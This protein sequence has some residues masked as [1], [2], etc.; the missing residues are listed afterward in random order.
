MK[1]EIDDV[2]TKVWGLFSDVTYYH[3]GE[4]KEEDRTR[5]NL[6]ATTK[7]VAHIHTGGTSLDFPLTDKDNLTVIQR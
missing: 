2:G 7:Y 1:V 4:I 5:L 6:P 3:V